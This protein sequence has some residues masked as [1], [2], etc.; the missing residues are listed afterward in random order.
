[1]IIGRRI[2]VTAFVLLAFAAIVLERAQAGDN[3]FFAPVRDPLVLEECG[4]CHLAFAP[5][6]LPASSWRRMM[7]E[8]DNHFGDNASLEPAA[9]EHI[10][11]YLVANAGDAAGQR[12]GA[13]MLRGVA[14]DSAP[15]RITTLP[16]WRHKHREVPDWEWRHKEVLSRANCLACHAGAEQ[17]YYDDD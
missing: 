10:T 16:R 8:L 2:I 4:G 3:H 6:M 14:L 9:V 15:Q 13:K 1:M 5:S 11:R 7:G 12:H 17:G